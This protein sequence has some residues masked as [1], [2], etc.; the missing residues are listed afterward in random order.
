LAPYRIA[1]P[2]REALI[3]L[4][5]ST[6]LD[7]CL[8]PG[9]PGFVDVVPPS[10]RSSQQHALPMSFSARGQKAKK[11]Q[12]S[13]LVQQQQLSQESTSNKHRQPSSFN[14]AQSVASARFGCDSYD[15]LSEAYSHLQPGSA[16]PLCGSHQPT[17]GRYLP[18]PSP[19]SSLPIQLPP[20]HQHSSSPPPYTAYSISHLSVSDGVKYALPPISTL[21]KVLDSGDGT[22]LDAK[23]VL[24]RLRE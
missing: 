19:P 20:I 7:T 4:F 8:A 6:F 21:E 16:G 18:Y 14:P 15:G 9:Q 17:Q 24:R 2:I 13:K 10:A 3:P 1:W 12:S 22:A 11:R 23:A 5:G